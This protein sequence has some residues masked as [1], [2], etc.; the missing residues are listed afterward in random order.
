M[1]FGSFVAPM[2]LSEK[3]EPFD[4]EDFIYEIK[5][6][7]IRATLHASS[8]GVKIYSRRGNDL[9]QVFPELQCIKKSVEGK[10]IFDGEIIA[11]EN[12]VPS[13]SKLQ[14]RTRLRDGKKIR[15]MSIEEPVAFVAFDCLYEGKDLRSLP[16]LLRKERLEK[17]V[18]TEEFVK[19]KFV[20]GQGRKLFS[21]IVKLGLEGIVAKRKDSLYM[22]GHRTEDWIKIKNFACDKFLIGGIVE[23]KEK[24]SL[25]LG[26]YRD[27]YLFFVGKVAIMRNTSLYG[28]VAKTKE[29]N[30]SPFVD[31]DENEARFIRP[32]I[33]CEVVYIERTPSGHLRQ[34][35]LK[36][37]GRDIVDEG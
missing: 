30:K 10:V 12:G 15:V 28:K 33:S 18:D 14:R 1:N 32:T 27:G 13:F 9:T 37:K 34:P 36:K 8:S 17:Y 19:A 4:D 20:S 2:L 29:M 21:R 23:N 31:Y 25:L 3:S 11:F 26:E 5:F 16:L 7:G 22:T 24:A 35:V 6:D